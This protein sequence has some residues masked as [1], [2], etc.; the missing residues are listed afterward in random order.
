[1][2]NKFPP[3]PEKCA[4]YMGMWKI[5]VEPDRPQMAMWRMSIACCITKAYKHKHTPILILMA[6]PLQ[7][8][9]HECAC[10]IRYLYIACLVTYH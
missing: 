3:A 8:W 9:L 7:Q 10:M 2:C 6:F 5:M 4:V 1:M